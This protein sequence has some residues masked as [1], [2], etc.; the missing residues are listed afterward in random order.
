MV[1]FSF[2]RMTNYFSPT[3]QLDQKPKIRTS[4]IVTTLW[5]LAI[6]SNIG[7]AGKTARLKGVDRQFKIR[8]PGGIRTI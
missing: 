3:F 4:I 7:S 1:Y 5:H 2:Y 6:F 8:P